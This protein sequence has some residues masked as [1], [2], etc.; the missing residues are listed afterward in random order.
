MF[1]HGFS[2][3]RRWEAGCWE[4]GEMD[5]RVERRKEGGGCVVGRL[6]GPCG[7]GEVGEWWK[8]GVW[9]EKGWCEGSGAGIV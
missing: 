3:A 8:V 7:G 9:L 1:L 6:D 4:D 2:E 5:G